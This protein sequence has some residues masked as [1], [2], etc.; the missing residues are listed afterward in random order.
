MARLGPPAVWRGAIGDMR[1]PPLRRRWPART[2]PYRANRKRHIR[3]C[4]TRWME[5]TASAPGWPT[6]RAPI[7]I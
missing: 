3:C 4:P 7:E 5:M 2:G 1:R 6:S